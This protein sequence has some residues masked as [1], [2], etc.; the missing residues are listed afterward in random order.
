MTREE[1]LAG[2]KQGIGGS[3]AAK[4][5][6]ISRWGGPFTVW[7]EKVIGVTTVEESDAMHFGTIL[8]EVVAREFSERTG[9]KVR[10]R[11]QMTF[12]KDFPFLLANI[13]R[14]IVGQNAGLE[15]KTASAYKIDEWKDDE[16]PDEYF[17]QV[18][19][20][21]FV[22]GWEGCWIACLV[23]GQRFIYKYIPRNDDFIE[24][25]VNTEQDF[26]NNYVLPKIAPSLNSFDDVSV[27]DQTREDTL[28]ATKADIE[29]ASRLANIRAQIDTLDGQKKEIEAYFKGRIM[30][31]AG[32]DGIA[33]W[34]KAKDSLTTDWKSVAMELNPSLDIVR[35]YTVTKEGSRRF[36]FKF[37]FEEA[38]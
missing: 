6:G 3:D 37:K 22:M 9:L 7:N 24:P 31:S 21:C 13:D 35:K 33:T 20:Y 34:K 8:E 4:V 11:N 18:Q 29:I 23:G 10:R 27:I 25:M 5:L 15:C 28:E 16:L 30:E 1:F 12:H 36:L 38:V 2:R 26:W 17:V 19:H 32:I 14:E